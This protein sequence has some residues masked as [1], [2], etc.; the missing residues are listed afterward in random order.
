MKLTGRSVVKEDGRADPNE[1]PD[2]ADLD[3]HWLKVGSVVL[4]GDNQLLAQRATGRVM[5][6]RFV[7]M[8]QMQMQRDSGGHRQKAD[9]PQSQTHSAPTPTHVA[10]LHCCP[11]TFGLPPSHDTSDIRLR[12]E[13]AAG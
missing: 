10:G 4:L 3:I 8:G 11:F 13:P 1:A 2:R 5:V 7:D 12:A 9:G 6:G